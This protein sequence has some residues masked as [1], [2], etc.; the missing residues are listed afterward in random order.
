MIKMTRLQ[1]RQGNRRSHYYW[2]RIHT[3]LRSI[4]SSF[5]DHLFFQ[6]FF[7]SLIT[8]PTVKSWWY[9]SIGVIEGPF[10]QD[11]QRKEEASP[12]GPGLSCDHIVKERR[13]LPACPLTGILLVPSYSWSCLGWSSIQRDWSY[14]RGRKGRATSCS[15]VWLP[16]FIWLGRC[17]SPLFGTC[18]GGS[19]SKTEDSTRRPSRV[20]SS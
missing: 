5:P 17:T 18:M 3:Y 11:G 10:Y 1:I 7:S 4:L 6:F 20:C 8:A 9:G 15:S 12:F 14:S 2:W 19:V 13:F 16:L